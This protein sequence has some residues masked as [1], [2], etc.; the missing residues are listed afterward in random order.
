VSVIVQIASILID[1]LA[2]L[3]FGKWVLKQVCSWLGWGREPELPG[4]WFFAV[5][6]L[7]LTITFGCDLYQ[8]WVAMTGH[9]IP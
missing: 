1:I 9:P 3:Y 4:R 2:G 7:S 5:M 6:F 8:E